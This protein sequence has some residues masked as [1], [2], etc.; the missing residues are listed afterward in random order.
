[1]GTGPLGIP[2]E[3]VELRGTE[4]GRQREPVLAVQLVSVSVLLCRVVEGSNSLHEDVNLP[5]Q[6]LLPGKVGVV[7]HLDNL[8][9]IVQPDREVCVHV[10]RQIVVE[11]SP[12][13]SSAHDLEAA[14][15]LHFDVILVG[16][17]P[18]VVLPEPIADAA[19]DEGLDPRCGEDVGRVQ[20]LADRALHG[21]AP[22]RDAP[23][24]QVG[25]G[26]VLVPLVG[27]ITAVADA[28]VAVPVLRTIAREMPAEPQVAHGQ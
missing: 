11:L 13:S 23:L 22:D 25:G 9:D 26:E 28:A 7:G 10:S 5:L 8:Q 16:P 1:M 3:L 12:Q 17:G 2:G 19:G 4:Q 14:D 27:D 24:A 18:G 6:L 20:V 15:R 21:L